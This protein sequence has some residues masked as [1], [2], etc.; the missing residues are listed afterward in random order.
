MVIVGQNNMDVRDSSE[1]S[2]EV[3]NFWLYEDFQ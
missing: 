3:E 2:F 1:M